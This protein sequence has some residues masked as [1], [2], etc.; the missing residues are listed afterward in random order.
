MIHQS[1]ITSLPVKETET[2]L[3]II[4]GGIAGM[5]TALSAA[6]HG[7]QVVLMQDRPV[8]GGNASSEVRM[9]IRGAKG[10]NM[11]ETGILE[12]L[13]LENLYRNPKLNY[14]VWDSVM[15]GKLMMENNITLIMNCS[16][17]DAEME[18]DRIVSVTGWQTTTQSYHKVK[19]RIFADCSGD[20]ILAPLTG[21]EW[22]M[23]RESCHEF[24]EDIAPEV[25]MRRPWGCPV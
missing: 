14:S 16:C 20:S 3:C 8:L 5:L 11:R 15:Y 9:W 18:G 24:N 21:A 19:A 1:Q 10:P 6:R 12:E 4:G 2:E 25:S 13:A 23:G 7:R 17:L 22:R